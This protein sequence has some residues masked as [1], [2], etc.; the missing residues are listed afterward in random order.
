MVDKMFRPFGK[1]HNGN[2]HVALANA[3]VPLVGGAMRVFECV[4]TVIVQCKCDPSNEPFQIPGIHQAKVC[5]KC[6]NAYAITA[7]NYIRE[8]GKGVA[9]SV[10][11]ISK[12]EVQP[13]PPQGDEQGKGS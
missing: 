4:P 6:G 5:N 8:G 10:S 3:N 7:V 12:Q 1:P 9:C 13:P 11:I 2:G